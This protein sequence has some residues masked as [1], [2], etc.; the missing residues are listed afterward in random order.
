MSSDDETQTAQLSEPLIVA[1]AALQSLNPSPA[2]GNGE[3][4]LPPDLESV[5]ATPENKSSEFADWMKNAINAVAAEREPEEPEERAAFR[6]ALEERLDNAIQG[7]VR[8]EFENKE[9]L[10][11]E[12]V[13]Q[14]CKM[15]EAVVVH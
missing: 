7:H 14:F 11:G 9:E 15:A 13:K 5:F 6:T 1:L 10:T 2:A 3:A 12:K 4:Q 8:G